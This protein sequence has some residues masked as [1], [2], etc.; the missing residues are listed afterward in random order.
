MTKRIIVFPYKMGSAG[1]KR[2]AETLKER[3][4]FPVLRV[5]SDRDYSPKEDDFIV[6]WGAGYRAQ[7]YRKSIPNYL[8]RPDNVA[9]SV[10]KVESLSAFEVAGV[11]CPPFT[12]YRQQARRW[13]HTDGRVVVRGEVG[14]RDGAGLLVATDHAELPMAPLYTRFVPTQEEWRV[15]VMGGT[16]IATQRKVRIEGRPDEADAIRV[17]KTGWG[18]SYLYEDQQPE[19]VENPAK[20]AVRVLGLDFAAVD[21]GV[22]NGK[23]TV[24]EVNTAPELS[25]LTAKYYADALVRLANVV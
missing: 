7:W 12:A 5:Y 4:P 20:A 14:G 18:L 19:C 3:G 17:S 10:D 24:F 15:H 9:L 25:P 21:I 23:A 6:G 16:I 22:Y 2:L 11:P 1:G 8:N 13:C